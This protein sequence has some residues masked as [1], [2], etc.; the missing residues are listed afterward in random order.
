MIVVP[1]SR[2]VFFDETCRLCQGAVR[3]IARRDPRGVIRFCPLQSDLG[4][5]VARENNLDPEQSGSLVFYEND[6]FYVRSDGALRIARHLRFPWPI[7]GLFRVI[8]RF[9]RDPVYNLIAK[10]RYRW[11]GRV[12]GDWEAADAL[13][14]ARLLE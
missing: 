6:T 13:W 3:F 11:F 9:L 4:R 8:P 12:D 10:H 1:A 5:E 14:R 7:T 2:V